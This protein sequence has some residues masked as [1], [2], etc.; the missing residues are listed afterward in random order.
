MTS[1]NEMLEE[2]RAFRIQGGAGIRVHVLPREGEESSWVAGEG[3]GKAVPS[4]GK[5]RCKDMAW[6]RGC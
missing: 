6:I 2:L 3:S 5:V 1:Q 4:R